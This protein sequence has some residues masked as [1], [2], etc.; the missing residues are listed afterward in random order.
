MLIE[1]LICLAFG[2]LFLVSVMSMLAVLV[3]FDEVVTII[4]EGLGIHCSS[5]IR[6]NNRRRISFLQAT[7]GEGSFE[8][9]STLMFDA[10]DEAS[11]CDICEQCERRAP[12]RH[13]KRPVQNKLDVRSLPP[14]YQHSG[15][16]S[17]PSEDPLA[18]LIEHVINRRASLAEQYAHIDY[19][20][21]DTSL[22]STF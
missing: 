16:T 1:I 17:E 6:L 2:S 4:L 3:V 9:S 13:D 18:P 5:H 7:E 15:V 12:L 21:F 14:P 11:V 22:H 8:R 10:D 20:T 19:N